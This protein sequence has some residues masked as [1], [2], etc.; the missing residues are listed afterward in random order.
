MALIQPGLQSLKATNSLC[1]CIGGAELQDFASGDGLP[2]L[3]EY[4]T[5]VLGSELA[6]FRKRARGNLT[7]AHR[8]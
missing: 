2:F 4:V 5:K 7:D 1:S 8:T 3:L 6:A